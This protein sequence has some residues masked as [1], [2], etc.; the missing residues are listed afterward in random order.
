[1]CILQLVL[2][3]VVVSCP[4]YPALPSFASSA[5]MT[6]RDCPLLKS[7]TSCEPRREVVSPFI[8]TR[9]RQAR[10]INLVH[11]RVVQVCQCANCYGTRSTNFVNF[12]PELASTR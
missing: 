9:A 10:P 5:A 4:G 8:C 1:M 6:M 12:L 11:K 2:I 3:A 7:S